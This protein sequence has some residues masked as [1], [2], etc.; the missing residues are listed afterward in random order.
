MGLNLTRL[1]MMG[2]DWRLRTAACTGLLF[3]PAR[4]IVMWTMV[5]WYRLGVTPNMSTRALWQP[6]VVSGGPVSRDISGGSRRMGEW[7][8][9]YSI[10]PHGTSRELQHAVKPYDIRPPALLPI[11]RKVCWGLLS[12]LKIHR[13]GRVRTREISVQWQAH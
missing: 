7:M 1:V 2:W 3:I 5:W 9:I 6:P 12:P 13:L 4:V 10:R 8:R 11:R